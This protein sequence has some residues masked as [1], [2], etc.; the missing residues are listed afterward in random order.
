MRAP[1]ARADAQH[2]GQSA[3]ARKHGAGLSRLLHYETRT[4]RGG[5]DA[6]A[7]HALGLL[8]LPACGERVGVRGACCESMPVGRPPHPARK[9]AQTSP[10]KRGEVEQAASWCI[11]STGVRTKPELHGRLPSERD[12]I[13]ANKDLRDW[14]TAIEAAGELKTFRGAEPKEE[15]G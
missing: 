11:N 15:I 13:V 12:D 10:R 1:A 9:S 3:G 2:T 6:R 4:H 7:R 5:I 8:P 14:I